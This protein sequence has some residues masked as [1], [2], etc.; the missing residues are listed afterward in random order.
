VASIRQFLLRLASIIRFGHVEDDLARE[1][2]AHLRLLEDKYVAEGMT[3]EEARLAAR[4]AFGGGVEQA[5]E[6]QRD[7]RSFRWLDDARADVIYAARS[8][9]RNPGF[10]V[11]AIFTLA[12]GIG[13][14]TAISSVADTVMLQPLPFPDGD[15]LVNLTE[16]GLDRATPRMHYQELLAWRARTRTLSGLATASGHPQIAVTTPNGTARLTAGI[17]S[18]NY[19]EVLGARALLGRTIVSSDEANPQVAMLTFEAWQRHFNADPDILGKTLDARPSSGGADTRF[20]TIVGVLPADHETLASAMDFYMAAE[21]VTKDGRPAGTGRL[22]G[23]LRDGVTL[24]AAA[25]EAIA[26]GDAIR[27]PRPVSAPPLNGPRF[28]VES[29]KDGLVSTLKPAL[30]IFLA[31]VAVLLLIVCANVA[32]LLLARGTARQREIAVRFALG[33]SRGRIVRQILTECLVLAI[34]GGVS[35][36]AFGA[37]GVTAIKQLATVDA[38]GVFRIVMG[39]SV[40]PRVQEVGVDPRFFAIAFGF[41]ALAC[42]LFGLLP[43]LHLSTTSSLRAIGTRGGGTARAETRTRTALIVTQLAMATVLLVG[44]GLLSRSFNNLS[45]VTKGYDPANVLAFQLVLPETYTTTRKA[46]T[47]AR[48]L[49]RLRAQPAVRAAGFA[50]AG[51]LIMVENTTG[52]FIPPGGNVEQLLAEDNRP[53]IKSVS[54][55]YLEAVGASVLGGRLFTEEDGSAA[56]APKIVIN[57]SVARRYFG[58]ANPVGSYMD[59]TGVK[60]GESARVEVIGVVEDIKQARLERDTYPEIFIDYRG[61]MT[62]LERWDRNTLTIDHLTFGFQSFAVRTTGEPRD[63]IPVVR[64]TVRNVDVNAGI[65]A[66][67][68]LEQLVAQ[69]VARQ[70]FYAVMLSSFAIVAA[71]LAAVG[72][73]GVLAYAVMQRTQEIG[74]RMA[75]GAQRGQ[76][77]ALVLWRGIAL[78]AAGIGIGLAAAAAGTRYLQGLLFGVLPLDTV[79]F[80]LTALGFVTLAALASYIPARRATRVDPMIA[81]RNE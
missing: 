61:L 27:P 19:F 6:H 4:R 34:T 21:S 53:R 20:L 29:V 59:W 57:R 66:I 31:A 79:T 54:P 55:G 22:I 40:L 45:S 80:A 35:G 26:L 62:T 15:R 69:S 32:N 1:V 49:D 70:R 56:T 47:F 16:R 43:A 58:Q 7:A 73:Y 68:P 39:S 41:S 46:E 8:L 5:K 11:S 48:I 3:Q 44:A 76:V 60:K 75:L 18:A 71:L 81:L 24:A 52:A 17:V 42:V 28:V 23:R 50:F 12:L 30:T 10:A 67:L 33:A 37:A 38:Q 51:I 36:A 72:I 78:A 74:V 77:L 25:E 13:A 9:R 65:D 64:Q 63:M 14:A 2:A